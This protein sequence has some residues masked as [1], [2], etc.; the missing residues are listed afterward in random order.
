MK[1]SI[2]ALVT[3]LA[4]WPAL[5][6][7][8]QAEEISERIQ[9]RHLVYGF[10]HETRFASPSSEEILHTQG[11]GDG[12]VWTGHYLAAE[13][14]R[15]AATRSPVALEYARRALMSI[16][17]LAEV[18]GNGFLTR[19]IIPLSSPW[20]D[21]FKSAEA[22]LGLF[23]VLY[24]G[25]PSYWIG[26]PTRD[27]YVGAFLGLASAYELIEDE[28][29]RRVAAETITKL[30][31]GLV[32]HGWIMGTPGKPIQETYIGRPD[33]R[34]SALQLARRVNPARF[35]KL[36]NDTRG[37]ATWLVGMATSLEVMDLHGSYYK[38][39]L[40]YGYFF[41]LIRF[42][43]PGSARNAYLKAYDNLR[44]KTRN[45]GNAH[46]NMID[47]AINGPDG[48][49]DAETREILDSL[50]SRGFRDH[51][52]DLRGR[53]EA[54]GENR[55]CSPVP[56]AERPYADFL[57]QR[58]PFQ[59]YGG[60]DGSGESAGLDYILPYWMARYHGVL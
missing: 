14:Y 22:G 35:G 58:S 13:A 46:F 48:S 16:K 15:Y 21:H 34:L 39:N 40:D 54:C 18:P 25:E 7:D 30:V 52:V 38:F 31:D 12:G 43:G 53:Y 32:D 20:I 37:W 26:H 45:H 3:L 49:R 41:N 6:D 59:L 1:I 27:Q 4:S 19:Y 23:E 42:E 36:Y 2:L 44:Q 33:H 47:H 24:K 50:L 5:A 10:I 57:W 17:D 29:I 55:A 9:R 60:A 28:E 8:R 11:D 51:A 56:V